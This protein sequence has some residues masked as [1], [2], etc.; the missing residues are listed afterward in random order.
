MLIPVARPHSQVLVNSSLLVA[1]KA[2]GKSL[3]KQFSDLLEDY[4]VRLMRIDQRYPLGN[5]DRPDWIEAHR[6]N[7]IARIKEIIQKR[8]SPNDL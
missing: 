3:D 1:P 4:N 6:R 7:G 8:G 2:S 5:P